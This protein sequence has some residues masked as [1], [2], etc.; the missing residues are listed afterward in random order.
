MITDRIKLYNIRKD[1][2]IDA[3]EV[4]KQWGIRPDQV[5]DLQ[6]LWGDSTDNV[7]GV[8][9]DWAEDGQ[10]VAKQV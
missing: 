4:A 7:P 2:E 10:R 5:V 8:P 9:G 1:Q 6:A 3:E